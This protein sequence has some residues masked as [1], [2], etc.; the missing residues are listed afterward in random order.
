MG[1]GLGT[2]GIFLWATTFLRLRQARKEIE[3][4]MGKI[5]YTGCGQLHPEDPRSPRDWSGDY[6]MPVVVPPNAKPGDVVE[7]DVK[8]HAFWKLGGKMMSLQGWALRDEHKGP[9]KD[10]LWKLV[11]GHP[12]VVHWKTSE[13]HKRWLRN[14]KTTDIIEAVTLLAAAKL[15]VV[16]PRMDR[17]DAR[18]FWRKGEEPKSDIPQPDIPK[19]DLPR[20]G[21]EA[22]Q[23]S[24]A[25]HAVDLPT[26]SG[27]GGV[28]G[29]SS[30]GSTG[31]VCGGESQVG[32]SQNA[33]G[34][35]KVT[36]RK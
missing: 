6:K 20:L 33:P 27:R 31:S 28:V 18:W 12:E 4:T 29:V 5:N 36:W 35:A 19:L 22:K 11:Q 30:P 8:L 14:I 25:V 1:V 21:S 10:V 23:P 9:L 34:R 17:R 3:A 26:G 13:I 2:R 7:V 15:I 24:S 16:D 32:E